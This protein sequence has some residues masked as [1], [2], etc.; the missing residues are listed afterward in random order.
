MDHHRRIRICSR[1]GEP[2]EPL[3]DY[4]DPDECGACRVNTKAS[5]TQFRIAMRLTIKDNRRTH[6]QDRDDD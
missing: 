2:F 4:P 3:P 6:Q 1:C 5:R